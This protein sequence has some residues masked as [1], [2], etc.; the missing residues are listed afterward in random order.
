M[1]TKGRVTLPIEKGI[2]QEIIKLLDRWGADAV[3]N[4][5][6][7]ELIAG[8]KD[9]HMK[10]Y[11]SYFPTRSD[12]EWARAHE[13]QVQQVSLMTKRITAV[14]K[15]L[16]INIMNGFFE[17]QFK[18]NYNN[19][20]KKWWEVI[21]RTTGK[22]LHSSKWEYDSDNDRVIINQP[23]L[24][25]TY[26]VSFFAFQ[27]WDSTQMYNHITNN[28]TKPHE[29]PYDVRHDETKEHVLEYLEK[30]LK[31]NKDV[32]VVRFTTFFY[33]FTLIFNEMAK[34]KFVDWFGYSSSVSP[35]AL[36]AFEEEKGYKISQ[37]DIVDEGYYNTPF[38]IPKQVFRDYIDFQQ[39][40]VSELAHEC[41][42]LTHK[43]GKEAMMFLGDNWIGTEPYGKYFESIGLDA[44]VGS[45]G[46]GTTLRMIADIPNVEY[47]EGR[48]LPYFFPDTFYEGNDV[49]KETNEIWLAARRA[50][51]RNP[52]D[53]MGY[54][55]YLS[56]A[57]KFPEFVS[58]IEAICDEFREIHNNMDNKKPYVAPFKVA[59]LN[60]WGN[61]R[62][63]QTNQ[64][65][66]ALW[67]KKIYS[68][69]GVI[70][71]LSGMAVDVEFISFDD[72]IEKDISDDIGVIIN[73]GDAGTSW[74]GGE[75]WA[76]E[77]LLV[78][79]RKWV[80]DGGGFIGIGEPTAYQRQGCYFQLSD[81][82]GVDKETGYTLS[83]TNY[84]EL[85]D[86][87][88]I[89]QDNNTFDCG[90]GIKW[91]RSASENTEILT[92][93]EGDINLAVNTYG[94]G[95]SVYM[96]GLPYSDENVDL[97]H[98]SIYWVTG[99]GDIEY[100]WTTDNIHTECAC[101]KE[102]GKYIVINN[103]DK[104]QKTIVYKERV[105]DSIEIELNPM[106]SKWFNI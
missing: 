92:M 4:S 17:E 76:Q 98:R 41:V 42:A 18:V 55:G 23:I 1:K 9:S 45:V 22:V 67:Y 12:Q 44:V 20:P 3:R 53:R 87:H 59:I 88:F 40:F 104:I 52:V 5:D 103:S 74:S 72:I 31:E 101:Y 51:L 83:Y 81:V 80:Y 10:V 11:S 102:A 16:T 33:H 71:C 26:T 61:L 86:G 29:I 68:Y 78:K 69:V 75:Y 66:H 93:D 73:A 82:L 25:H 77:E 60:A 7:T 85:T 39:K 70:E 27:V 24:F 8:I 15:P 58:R 54:G 97:L 65:A 47:T 56:L 91:I 64:V 100:K 99:N 79:L 35:E 6:G 96:S 21:D 62:K 57:L 37:E 90:E 89:L 43:Y 49:M 94:K 34:E 19:D 46:N 63:W 30:W 50:L 14:N 105:N 106:E 38:R 32:D 48:F 36:K 84:D 95:R 13:E 2:E 28:W